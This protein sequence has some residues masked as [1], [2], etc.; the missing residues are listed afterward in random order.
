MS[1]H[2]RPWE[3]FAIFDRNRPLFDKRYG[4]HGYYG[5]LIG[6]DR[7]KSIHMTLNELEG[8]DAEGSNFLTYLDYYARMV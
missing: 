8:R 5:S 7:S 4:T 1:I 2:T 3:N 6:F